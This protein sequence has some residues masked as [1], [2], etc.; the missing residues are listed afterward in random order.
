MGIGGIRGERQEP[1][2]KP[3]RKLGVSFCDFLVFFVYLLVGFGPKF[4]TLSRF[5]YFLGH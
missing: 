2:S 4:S 5:S 3:Q 1:S